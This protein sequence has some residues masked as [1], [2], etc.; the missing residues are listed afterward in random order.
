MS[1]LA[2]W[3]YKEGPVTVWP[4]STDEFGQANYGTSY[5]IP[6]TDQ[7][8]GGEIMRDDAGDEFVPRLTIYFEADYNDPVVP[9]RNWFMK[10]GDHTAEATPPKDADRIRSVQSWPMSKFGS[11]QLPDWKVSA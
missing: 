4:Y 7:E 2:S 1:T 10:P 8:I 3:S 9:K 11:S 6:A 5:L